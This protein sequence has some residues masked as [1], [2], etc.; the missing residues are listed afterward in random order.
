MLKTILKLLGIANFVSEDTQTIPV[1][2]GRAALKYWTYNIIKKRNAMSPEITYSANPL[3]NTYKN[4]TLLKILHIFFISCITLSIPVSTL[5]IYNRVTANIPLFIIQCSIPV[6]YFNL[7]RITVKRN[8]CEHRL[9]SYL[10]IL[11]SVA[12]SVCNLIFYPVKLQI[13][14]YFILFVQFFIG[15]LI[16]FISIS[17]FGLILCEHSKLL[18]NYVAKIKNLHKKHLHDLSGLSQIIEDITIMRNKTIMAEEDLSPN[19]K[20]VT[21]LGSMSVAFHAVN[22]QIPNYTYYIY[23]SIYLLLQILYFI[24]IYIYKHNLEN[25]KNLIRKPEFVN[26]YLIRIKHDFTDIHPIMLNLLEENA[27]S[28]DWIVLNKILDDK[29]MDFEILGISINEENMVSRCI[30]FIGLIIA[31]FNYFVIK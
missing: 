14:L 13:Y 7:V 9:I 27:T 11:C 4:L 19:F 24:N 15:S 25:L 6:Q 29:W 5:L 23:F 3:S 21:L 18:G 17:L 2:S 20:T 12:C 8:Q 1:C 31:V 22:S 26:K 28:I 10:I 16:L 30:T